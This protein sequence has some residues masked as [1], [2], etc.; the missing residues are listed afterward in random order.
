MEWRF[1]IKNRK[2]FYSV[3]GFQMKIILLIDHNTDASSCDET[4]SYRN[5]GPECKD[6]WCDS[7]DKTFFEIVFFSFKMG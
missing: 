3:P 1:A 7:E 5:E 4:E 6:S 2:K